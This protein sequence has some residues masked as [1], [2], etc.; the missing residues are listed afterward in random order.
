MIKMQTCVCLNCNNSFL[1]EAKR[2]KSHSGKIG[3]KDYK[4]MN[5]G[6]Y[7]SKKCLYESKKNKLQLSCPNCSKPVSRTPSE[8]AKTTRNFCS[9]S[10]AAI[11]NNTHKTTG[12]R[13]SKLEAYIEE[14]LCAEFPNLE[15][16]C[17]GKDAIGSELDFYFPQLRLAIELNGIF[18]YE[19]IYGVDK[20]EQVQRN[21]QQKSIACN[22]AGIEFCIID[23]S[24]VTNNT[25]AVK[26][27]YWS[28][29]KNLV[30]SLLGRVN[31]ENSSVRIA[32][33]EPATSIMSR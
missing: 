8:M 13:R 22:Q 27:R 17:N 23:T 26:D 20:L 12:T 21:D 28:I 29:V 2:L 6:R 30:T 16:I 15:L 3:H 19:P 24:T 14:Q 9:S 10:C 11:Y 18:H 33:I 4:P 32:G 5:I 7:C 1:I 31:T 25:K